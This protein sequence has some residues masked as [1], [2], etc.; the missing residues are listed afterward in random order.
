V[1]VTRPPEIVMTVPDALTPEEMAALDVARGTLERVAANAVALLQA[2]DAGETELD[3][4]GRAALLIVRADLARAA[5]VCV[6]LP[7]WI[8][9]WRERRAT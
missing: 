2:D 5:R 1:V 8:A 9:T 3:D 4:D 7:G 6:E